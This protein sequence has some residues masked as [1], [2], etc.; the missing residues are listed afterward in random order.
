MSL[1]PRE[2]LCPEET[3]SDVLRGQGPQRPRKRVGH[4]L[5]L[6]RECGA[7]T[8]ISAGR[9][10]DQPGEGWGRR[11]PRPCTPYGTVVSH[12]HMCKSKGQERKAPVRRRPGQQHLTPTR[13]RSGPSGCLGL[14]Q[15]PS[16]LS[17][18]VLP[19]HGPHAPPG[20]RTGHCQPQALSPQS[21]SL[22]PARRPGDHPERS[23]V[24]RAA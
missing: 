5:F 11:G 19:V 24:Q 22:C 7:C 18:S 2:S 17:C 14:G 4:R 10:W 23:S 6:Q 13:P 21:S 16:C 1:G 20:G 8:G 3:H 9:C 15:A 12:V